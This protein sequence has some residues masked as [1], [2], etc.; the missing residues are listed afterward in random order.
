MANL[1]SNGLDGETG[2]YRKIPEEVM[3]HRQPPVPGLESLVSSFSA[4]GG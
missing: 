3:T 1:L 2:I 4:A